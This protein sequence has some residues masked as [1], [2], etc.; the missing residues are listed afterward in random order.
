MIVRSR[1]AN[2]SEYSDV[3]VAYRSYSDWCWS[4][5]WC[6]TSW[7]TPDRRL[8]PPSLPVQLLELELL[9]HPTYAAPPLIELEIRCQ[10][11]TGLLPPVAGCTV[12]TLIS[13]G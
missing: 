9:T 12:V 5:S 6:P 2:P 11:K 13:R 10:T 1:L 3:F 8:V 4:P 7:A